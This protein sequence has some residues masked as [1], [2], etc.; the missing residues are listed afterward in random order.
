MSSDRTH[1]SSH[2]QD[3]SNRL[4][5]WWNSQRWL[6]LSSLLPNSYFTASCLGTHGIQAQRWGEE[7]QE[8]V[9]ELFDEASPELPQTPPLLKNGEREKPLK[10]KLLRSTGWI[11]GERGVKPFMKSATRQKLPGSTW[12]LAKGLI[13][14]IILDYID[15]RHAKP[16]SKIMDLR[17]RER[18]VKPPLWDRLLVRNWPGST[19]RLDNR[20]PCTLAGPTGHPLW[21]MV[22]SMTCMLHHRAKN[23]WKSDRKNVKCQIG[24]KICENRTG[25]MSSAKKK[26]KGLDL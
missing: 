23:L 11:N 13:F 17:E 6:L 25:K 15:F 1:T 9:K 24:L 19:W 21:G 18:G 16:I 12:R 10:K 22:A 14:R 3:H 20:E 5:S 4:A 8:A 2:P 7:G 26:Q